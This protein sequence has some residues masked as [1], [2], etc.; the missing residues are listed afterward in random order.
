MQVMVP[1]FHD[2]TYGGARN[3]KF[4]QMHRDVIELLLYAR[5][6]LN[7]TTKYDRCSP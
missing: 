7:A 1:G 5:A 6:Y 2:N 4:T 3:F